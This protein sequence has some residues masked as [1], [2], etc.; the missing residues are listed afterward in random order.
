MLVEP[1]SE[2]VSLIT[3]GLDSTSLLSTNSLPTVDLQKTLG[4]G[5]NQ[6]EAE[7]SSD[8]SDSES[9]VYLNKVIP[10]YAKQ[11][12]GELQNAFPFEWIVQFLDPVLGRLKVR[13]QSKYCP[14]HIHRL[15]K[16]LVY[17]AALA[18]SKQRQLFISFPVSQVS[19]GILVVTYYA[20]LCRE[21]RDIYHTHHA[22]SA[23]NFVIWVRP[24]N[25]GQIQRLD[26]SDRIC[27]LPIQKLDEPFKGNQLKVF[28]VRSLTEA[29][30][31]VEKPNHCS[32]IVIDDPSGQTYTVPSTY[33][34][35]AFELASVCG[36]KQ[37]PVIGIVPPWTLKSLEYHE[38]GNSQGTLLWPIDYMA[39]CSYPIEHSPFANI[40]APHPIEESNLLL[41]RKRQVLTEAQVII[42]TF[43][44][45]TEDEEKI[46][47]LFQESSNL[48]IHIAKQPHLR[49]VGVTGW[50]IWRDLSAP[51]LPFHLLWGSFIEEALKRL[52]LAT[53][54]SG[55]DRALTLYNLLKSLALRLQRLKLNPF[56]E[57][58]KAADKETVIAVEN[59]ERAS[60]LEQFLSGSSK[61]SY[62][63]QILPLSEVRGLGGEKLIVIGQPKACYRDLLQATFFREI[64]VLLWSVLAERAQ[65]WWSNLEVNAREWH[66]KTWLALTEKQE[67][68]YYGYSPHQVSVQVV[69]T[70]RAKLTKSIDLSKLEESFSN[71]SETNLDSGLTSSA[72][73]NLESHYLIEFERELKIRVAPGSELLVILGK[74]AQVVAI[75]E[76][77]AG[78]KVVLFDGMN[79]DELFAQKAGLLEDT[80]VNYLYR[81]QLQAW[82]GLVKEQVKKLGVE[83][84]CK[85]IFQDTGLFIR[86]ETIQTNWIG[87]KDLLSL[88]REKEHFFWFVPP[89]VSSNFEDF[90][91]KANKLRIKRRELGQ[92]ITACAQEG[93]KDR[94][95]DEIVFQY[96]RLFITI[97]ELRDAMQVLRVQ[98]KPRLIRQKPEYPVNRLFK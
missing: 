37:I 71:W 73:S 74:Q 26:L 75:G 83:T 18:I 94:K 55:D 41:V 16:D 39:L 35:A 57:I 29:I 33:G 25:N 59:A 56:M 1:S 98:S 64:N 72:S 66:R 82:R 13:K 6:Q 89:L 28:M 27:V 8:C 90:W 31:L 3:S 9:Q 7:Q 20:R 42:K 12:W 17:L 21:E 49:D 68:G 14:V 77:A 43:N 86:Q 67:V 24:R 69:N 80:K 93:W 2:E 36:R 79:R 44:F 4:S 70:G 45:D 88:P 61:F 46:T 97:G 58:V 63:P 38:A 84:V 52:E 50:K 54:R 76:L 65:K 23:K 32:L 30:D 81:I 53:G 91:Q 95:S 5:H 10:S 47:E 22:V 78:T 19:L 85:L 11:T 96:Q 15:E 92:K 51:V 40:D 48:L 87:G 62:L 34:S 60:A